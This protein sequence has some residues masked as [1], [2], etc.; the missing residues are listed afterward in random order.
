M[1]TKKLLLTLIF[2]FSSSVFA[3]EKINLY[4]DWV[5]QF[6]FAGYYIAKEKGFYNDLNLDVEIKEFDQNINIVDE[7]LKNRSSYGIGKSSL[8]LDKFN[9][10]DIV[11]ISSIFQESPLVLISLK[12]TNIHSSKDLENKKIMMTSDAAE[13]AS[14][15]AL[16]KSNKLDLNNISIQKH[17]YDLDDLINKKTDV[18]A[19]YI[20][21]EPNILNK[22]NI[23]FNTLNSNQLNSNF[24]EGILFTSANEALQNPLN[25]QSFNEASLKGWKYAFENIEESAKIIFEKYNSHN[26]N[27]EDL[28]YEAN[29]LKELSKFDQGLLGDISFDRIEDIKKFYTYSGINDNGLD[30]DTNSI[31]F[32]KY[33]LV[34]NKYQKNYLKDKHF[35]LFVEDA[36]IPFSFKITN[37][38]KGIEIDFWNLISDKLSKPFSIEERINNKNLNIFSNTV[39]ANFTYSID[40]PKDDK[41]IYTNHIVQIPLAIATKNDK[42]FISNLESLP[43]V[44]IGFLSNLNLKSLLERTYPN[45]NFIE[46]NSRDAGFKDLKNGTIFG[47]IDNIYS[48][49]SV[50]GQNNIDSIK[51]NSSMD[52]DLN[53]FM[54]INNSDVEFRDILN[55]VIDKLTI[56]ERKFILNKYQQILYH[57]NISYVEMAKF[58]IPLILLLAIFVYLNLKLRKEIKKRKEAQTQ[59]QKLANKDSLTNIFNRRKIEEICESEIKRLNR[60]SNTFSIIFFDLNDFKPIND[61]YGHQA[62]DEVLVKIASCIGKSIRASDSFGRWGG[63]EFLII[64]PQTTFA[65]AQLLI[66]SLKKNLES[67][68]FDFNKDSKI[69][70]SFGAYEYKEGDNLDSLIKKADEIMYEIKT[71]YKENKK[72]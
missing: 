60:Y 4:L 36:Q 56:D 55:R 25:V 3:K 24:Y 1:C 22:K 10:K 8:I 5:D 14:I 15:K 63:D 30:F 27:L 42:N 17:S 61:I 39:K 16:F 28:L 51:I 43:K 70:C 21:N 2:V 50:I 71:Q 12:S 45:I 59:L 67:I 23:E 33:N 54:Q 35:T 13:S 6:Q 52:I 11:L 64:L 9:N 69:S 29:I 19:C 7:V 41:Y 62:G 48:L 37:E 49:S 18:M 32:D 68:V 66:E 44:D 20:S 46:I 65:Q 31:I 58:I 53:M 38:F 57:G 72:E 47:F 40:I 26:K 34:L